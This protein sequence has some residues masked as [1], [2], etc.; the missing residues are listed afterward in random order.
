MASFLPSEAVRFELRDGA[1]VIV[2]DV[3]APAELVAGDWSLLNQLTMCVV[4]GPGDAGFLLARVATTGDA[5]PA[6]WD[7]AVDRAAGG[8]VVFGHGA[9]APTVFARSL[10]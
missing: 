2:L 3:D 5:A 8:H 6:G 10:N 4:D 1:P 9:D 7:D